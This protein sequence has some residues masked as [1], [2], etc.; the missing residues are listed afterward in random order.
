MCMAIL[1][2]GC[3]GGAFYAIENETNTTMIYTPRDSRWHPIDEEFSIPPRSEVLVP[4]SPAFLLA[5]PSEGS[6]YEYEF[7]HTDK[8][9]NMFRSPIGPADTLSVSINTKAEVELKKAYKV[10]PLTPPFP[11]KPKNQNKAVESTP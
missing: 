7:E 9:A 5:N 1:L 2:S 11:L 4:Y 6:S 10:N 3:A 8:V